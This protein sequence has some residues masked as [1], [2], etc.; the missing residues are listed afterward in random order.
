[1]KKTIIVAALALPS[2]VAVSAQERMS[3]EQR[4]K[5]I[6]ERIG[7]AADR[8]AKDFDLKDDAKKSFV[9]TYTAYQKEM[10][11]TNQNQ[12]QRLEQNGRDGEKKEL[13]KEEAEARIKQNFERQEQQIATMQKRLEVQK[14]YAE[15]FGKVL[16]PQQVLK[17]L[18]PQRGQH[19]GRVAK[20]TGTTSVVEAS[21]AVLVAVASEA[22]IV[23]AALAAL[24]AVASKTSIIHKKIKKK[25]QSLAALDFFL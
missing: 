3:A 10:F 25:V 16:T 5:A 18:N 23:V 15:E 11:A 19:G 2:S 4:E 8:M 14:K 6:A 7:S 24:A 21:K 9:E 13:T 12:G 1:M 20:V 22:A 17:V